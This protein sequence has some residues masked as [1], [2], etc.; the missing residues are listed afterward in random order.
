VVRLLLR[1]I[2]PQAIL[3]RKIDS[4]LAPLEQVPGLLPDPPYLLSGAEY[5]VLSE[6]R[7]ALAVS[8]DALTA[9]RAVLDAH[10]SPI[11]SKARHAPVWEACGVLVWEMAKHQLGLMGRDVGID[12]KSVAVKFAALATKRMGFPGVT[13]LALGKRL[14]R[15][16]GVD[17]TGDP[18]T[19]TD[20]SQHR[21]PADINRKNAAFWAKHSVD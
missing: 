3:P 9:L 11:G 4:Y 19:G 12:R 6:A 10:N 21:T 8:R 1:N 5:N 15:L 20:V 16:S 17:T 14:E 13:P 18:P 7:H 2:D